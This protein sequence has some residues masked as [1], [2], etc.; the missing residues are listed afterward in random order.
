M[1]E[2]NKEFNELLYDK[3]RDLHELFMLISRLKSLKFPQYLKTIHVHTNTY[4]K[5][6][7]LFALMLYQAHNHS[8]V[9]GAC[10]SDTLSQL[11]SERVFTQYI[12]I[13]DVCKDQVFWQTSQ[14]SPTRLFSRRSW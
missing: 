3:T 9:A 11:T 1:K 12:G 13:T 5:Y 10:V 7:T 8:P 2:K 4:N 14:L 6:F